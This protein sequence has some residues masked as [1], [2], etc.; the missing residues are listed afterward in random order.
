MEFRY[1]ISTANSMAAPELGMRTAATCTTPLLGILSAPTS[2]G[3]LPDRGS[4][5]LIDAPDVEVIAFAP[6][7][8]GRSLVVLLQSVA[9]TTVDARISF[10]LL[11][12]RRAWTGSHLER[13]FEE[14]EVSGGEVRF[15]A[16]AGS[17]MS[18]A[19]DLE[20]MS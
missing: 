12:I 10:P 7:R 8:R 3:S 11:P 2:E 13:D 19:V 5:C 17:Y 6:S 1:S 4:F 18:L 14:V 15:A 9:P 20:S 16:P